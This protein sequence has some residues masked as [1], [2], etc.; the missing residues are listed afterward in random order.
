MPLV[1]SY[2]GE[3]LRCHSGQE[4]WIF[5]RIIRLYLRDLLK[6]EVTSFT[7]VCT[8]VD[9]Q[10]QKELKFPG[11]TICLISGALGKGELQA[12]LEIC[13][14]RGLHSDAGARSHPSLKREWGWRTPARRELR[15]N[16]CWDWGE[17]RPQTRR[18]LP[19]EPSPRLDAWH[20]GPPWE[21][22]GGKASPLQGRQQP[23]SW[24]G[25]LSLAASLRGSCTVLL[26][27]KEW[28]PPSGGSLSGFSLDA[29]WGCS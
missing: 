1:F 20:L 25:T 22:R 3:A 6:G 4:E 21:R 12:S 26:F 5:P 19:R 13:P 10:G 7:L 24:W 11:D 15:G 23:S 16:A 9:G 18:A 27:S 29:G 28:F 8:V 2:C 14:P 17:G